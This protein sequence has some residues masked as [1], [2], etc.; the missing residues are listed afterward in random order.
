M[1]S[2]LHKGVNFVIA[3]SG[4]A[5]SRYL[6][7]KI[8]EEVGQKKIQKKNIIVA[9]YNHALR[10]GESDRDE[11]FSRKISEQFGLIFESERREDKS[12]KKTEKLLEKRE[13]EHLSEEQARNLRYFF[14]EKIRKKYDAQCIVTAHHKDDQAETVFLQFLRGGGINAL[15]GMKTFCDER[16]LFRPLLTISKQKIVHELFQKKIDFCEDSTNAESNFTRN[17]LR[18]EVFP[19][20][21]QKF[22]GFSARLADKSGYFAQLQYEFEVHAQAFLQEK[23]PE[24]KGVRSGEREVFL[25]LL[26][27]VRFEVI[28]KIIFPKFCDEKFFSQVEDFLKNASSGKKLEIKTGFFQCFGE[29]VFFEKITKNPLTK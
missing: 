11:E 29:K 6:L 5:D 18:N 9:H 4:G 25:N 13:K 28:K 21:E 10:G 24:K 16:K 7:E 3:F 17:F 27:P 2:V 8:L 14:L 20:L 23:F 26:S 12:E 19:L 15:S 22:S 1:F